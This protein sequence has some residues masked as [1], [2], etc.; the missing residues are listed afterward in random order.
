MIRA[1]LDVLARGQA[2]ADRGGR[3]ERRDAGPAG[4]HPLDERALG[5]QFER[6]LSRPDLAFGLRHHARPGREARYQVTDLVAVGQQVR[7]RETRL[8]QPVA[9]DREPARSLL[10]QRDD[11]AGREAVGD[12]E[13]RDADGR[14]ILDVR[15]RGS[16]R[17]HQLVHGLT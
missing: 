15:H 14:A 12:A 3:V 2:G 4:P 5:Y 1:A 13:A 17:S 6:H 11:Q 9:V 10:A 16:R 8:A 7:G